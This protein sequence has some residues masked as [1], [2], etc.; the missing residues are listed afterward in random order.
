MSFWRSR[1][2]V[3]S[4]RL[5]LAGMTS[6]PDRG[7]ITEPGL[8]GGT[9]FAGG[10]VGAAFFGG[11]AALAGAAHLGGLCWGGLFW[12]GGL[13]FPGRALALLGGRPF[14][15]RLLGRL[16]ALLRHLLWHLLGRLLGRR[17]LHHVLL[18][19]LASGRGLLRRSSLLGWCHWELPRGR[20]AP[21]APASVPGSAG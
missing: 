9:F 18:G 14:R 5:G 4:E 15:G 7:Q 12:G 16:R 17:L 1:F 11:G 6:H 21:V 13:L 19:R 8:R 20:R 3:R 2:S 10:S